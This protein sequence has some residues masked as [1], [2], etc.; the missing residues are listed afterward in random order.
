MEPERFRYVPGPAS[1]RPCAVDG[2][3][4]QPFPDRDSEVCSWHAWLRFVEKQAQTPKTE[5]SR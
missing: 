5:V 1:L 4:C 2:E 3:M